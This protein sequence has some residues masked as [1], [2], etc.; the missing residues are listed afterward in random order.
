MTTMRV[1]VGSS[2]VIARTSVVLPAPVSPDTTTRM[3]ACIADASN[4]AIARSMLPLATSSDR[5]TSGSTL[6]RIVTCGTGDTFMIAARRD[7]SGRRSTSSG[8][9]SSKRRSVPPDRRARWAT[10]A[11]TSS[12]SRNSDW[13]TRSVRPSTYWTQTWSAPL[14]MMSV[15]PSSSRSDWNLPAWK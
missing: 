2:F 6:R 10:S 11:R 3:R 7:P 15:T 8:L 9:P 13:S 14:T 5:L 4:D 1:S 12:S